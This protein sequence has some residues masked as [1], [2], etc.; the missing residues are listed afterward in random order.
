MKIIVLSILVLSSYTV[1]GQGEIDYKLSIVSQYEYQRNQ[2]KEGFTDIYTVRNKKGQPKYLI[3]VI[4]SS[5][6]EDRTNSVIE[7]FY[8]DE[9]FTQ[10]LYNQLKCYPVSGVKKSERGNTEGYESKIEFQNKGNMIKMPGILYSTISARK[11][12]HVL[13]MTPNQETYNKS[14]SEMRNIL[15]SLQI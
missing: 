11:I 8:K 6:P 14:E 7:E 2:S 12:Y 1:F 13:F 15:N 10:S 5:L 4:M 3:Y 9:V